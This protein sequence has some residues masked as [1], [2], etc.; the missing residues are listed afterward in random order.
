MGRCSIRA[1]CVVED[2]IASTL[3][4]E[5]FFLASFLACTKLFVFRLFGL[6]SPSSNIKGKA[7]VSK[8][9]CARAPFFKI[10]LKTSIKQVKEHS[11][12]VVFSCW[13]TPKQVLLD[14]LP[15]GFDPLRGPSLQ[16]YNLNIS[17]PLIIR[18]R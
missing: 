14:L 16:S 12:L 4:T 8:V 10:F 17:F 6:F 1:N 7:S 18:D 5:R 9:N 3:L 11:V 15:L 2:K 13:V